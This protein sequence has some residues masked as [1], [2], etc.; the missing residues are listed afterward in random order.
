MLTCY[1]VLCPGRQIVFEL[2]HSSGHGKKQDDGLSTSNLNSGW[3]GKQSKMRVD[4]G[5]VLSNEDVGD[6]EFKVRGK[7]WRLYPGD[8]QFCQFT[9]NCAPP[10]DFSGK[11]K[12]PPPKHDVTNSDG[13]VKEFGYI[14]KPKGMRQLLLE[15]GL[16]YDGIRKSLVGRL[17][18]CKDFREEM[19]ALTKICV[20]KG[21]IL[22]MSPKGKYKL[23]F[24]FNIFFFN[25]TTRTHARTS[26]GQ[27]HVYPRAE[28]SQF[29]YYR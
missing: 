8:T 13:T 29:N 19:S 20:D 14:G 17:N 5:T 28:A 27:C 24:F 21:H 12:S 6:G 7:D 1:E 15:R 26:A 11:K 25:L 4:G 2:D 16:D 9:V 23:V 22:L 10:F 3:G 18:Q